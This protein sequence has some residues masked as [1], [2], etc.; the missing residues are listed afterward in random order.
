MGEEVEGSQGGSGVR[1]LC[2]LGEMGVI[3]REDLAQS[4]GARAGWG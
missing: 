1:G 2:F 3:S 4:L